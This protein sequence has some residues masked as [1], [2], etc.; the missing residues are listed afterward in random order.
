M[1][2]T[3]STVSWI[4]KRGAISTKPPI[5]ATPRIASM[6]PMALRSILRWNSGIASLPRLRDAGRE[7]QIRLRAGRSALDAG[8]PNGHQHVVRSDN[9]AEQE[10]QAAD[11]ARDVV[12]VHRHHRVNEGIGERA[13]I[14]IGA[15]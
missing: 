15:P 10:E 2:A 6:K 5:E 8:L 1:S 9:S 11:C 13:A 12:G 7:R 3:S 14:G 4:V